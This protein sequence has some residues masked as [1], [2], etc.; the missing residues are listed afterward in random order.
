MSGG[1]NNGSGGVSQPTLAVQPRP[2]ESPFGSSLIKPVLGAVSDQG[3]NNVGPPATFEIK[4]S[5]P[6]ER[7]PYGWGS[8]PQPRPY[9]MMPQPS[10]YG[11]QPQPSYYGMQPHGDGVV[12]PHTHGDNGQVVAGPDLQGGPAQAQMHAPQHGPSRSVAHDQ[13]IAN[14]NWQLAQLMRFR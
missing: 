2:V 13:A 6:V 3:P 7:N 9:G 1:G 4:T 14:G 11:M 12:P 10:Y 8:Q 5:Q